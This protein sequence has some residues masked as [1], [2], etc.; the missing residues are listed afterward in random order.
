[1]LSYSFNGYITTVME[2]SSRTILVEGTSDRRVYSRLLRE[3]EDRGKV[4]AGTVIIDSADMIQPDTPG[5]GNRKLVEQMHGAILASGGSIAAVV[6]REV[7]RV[8]SN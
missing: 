5:I 2:R 3:L 1:M 7:P 8:S 4:A 6:H